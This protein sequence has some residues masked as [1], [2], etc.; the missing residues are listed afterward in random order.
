M[1][2]TVFLEFTTNGYV[3]LVSQ[4][5]MSVFYHHFLMISVAT[6]TLVLIASIHEYHRTLPSIVIERL[7]QKMIISA[8]VGTTT[9]YVQ[10]LLF[11]W[12]YMH[13]KR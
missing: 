10:K 12:L 9:C 3:C 2:M 13:S 8:D 1:T 7:G 5:F 6:N 4:L 11:R